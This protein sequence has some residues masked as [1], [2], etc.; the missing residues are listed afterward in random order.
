MKTKPIYNHDELFTVDEFD[1]SVVCSLDSSFVTF[2]ID[3]IT[4]LVVSVIGRLAK[5]KA[6]SKI[7]KE[8]IL[9]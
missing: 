8:F 2:V 7:S 5:E 3:S 4:L 9:Y 6:E 1:T